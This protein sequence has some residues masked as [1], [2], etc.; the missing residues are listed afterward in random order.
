MIFAECD[1]IRDDLEAFAD[2]ELS[3][4]W[5]QRVG[6]HLEVCER[7]TARVSEITDLGEVLRAVPTF[8]PPA[9]I[10]GIA[11]RVISR[12]RAESAQSWRRLFDRAGDGWHWAAVGLG[13]VSSTFLVTSFLS[14]LLSFGPAP[15]RA[16]SLS[17]LINNLGSSPGIL[18]V[19]ATP[20]GQGGDSMLMQVDNGEPQ[21]ARSTAALAVP[22]GYRMPTEREM[23]GALA[24][25]MTRKGRVVALEAMLPDDRRYAESLLDGLN[26]LRM[27][28]PVQVG[29]HVAVHEVRL[30]TSTSVRAKG[31]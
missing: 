31:L 22:A 12:V 13:S 26:R 6:E 24:G 5:R 28:D 11:D 30:V 8:D 20:G 14:A 16:D 7:C 18:F 2:G 10:D 27:G 29:S 3:G 1:A 15:E 23:V 17:A 19:Y 25:A 9:D 21:A 4:A